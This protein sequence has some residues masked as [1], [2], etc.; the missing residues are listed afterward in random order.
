MKVFDFDNNLYHGESAVDLAFFM[1]KN[2]KR[3]LLWIPRILWNLMKYK[4]CLV[5]REGMEQAINKFLQTVIRDK[6]ELFQQTRQFW[7]THSHKLDK[8]IISLIKPDD[9]IISAGPDFLIGAVKKKLGTSNLL[10]SEINYEDMSVKYLNFGGNKVK[11][12]RQLYGD[13]GISAFFTDSYNDKAMMDISE[14][15]WLVSKGKI[16]RI[17]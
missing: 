8:R 13:A 1:I 9:I 6:E 4:L 14:K 17:R 7:K 10:C 11:R 16:K 12:F 5:N 15:V 3:I 2:N